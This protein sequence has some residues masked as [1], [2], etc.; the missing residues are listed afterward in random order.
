MTLRW[1]IDQHK[2]REQKA[3]AALSANYK[4]D[5]LGRENARLKK[6]IEELTLA[7]QAMWELLSGHLGFTDEHLISKMNEIDL[8]DG[9]LDGKIAD[10]IVT[11]PKCG[12]K[13]STAK[14]NCVYC[15]TRVKGRH[16]LK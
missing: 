16:I 9:Q 2:H 10:E 1:A 5:R 13:V 4:T 3:G 6:E 15:G 8:R 12:Q 14:P 7:S 11:C